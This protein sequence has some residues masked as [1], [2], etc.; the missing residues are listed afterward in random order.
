MTH[1]I[2]DYDVVNPIDV[3]GEVACPVLFIHEESDAFIT[4]EETNRLF[5][6]SGNPADEIWEVS[7]APH[8]ESYRTFPAEYT[9]KVD[10]FIRKALTGMPAG[11][12][13]GD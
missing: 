5:K 10:I 11:D 2:Y 9:E 6:A 7:G 13:P 1:I 4:W 3:V 12:V 8:S